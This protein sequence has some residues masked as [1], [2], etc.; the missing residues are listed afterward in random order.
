MTRDKLCKPTSRGDTI[1]V[2][3]ISTYLHYSLALASCLFVCSA[4]GSWEC[5]KPMVSLIALSKLGTKHVNKIAKLRRHSSSTLGCKPVRISRCY[6]TCSHTK[7][8]YMFIQLVHTRNTWTYDLPWGWSFPS[9]DPTPT[10]PLGTSSMVGYWD[11]LEGHQSPGCSSFTSC[12]SGWK[13]RAQLLQLHGNDSTLVDNVIA[14]KER[15]GLWEHH[16]DLV[17]VKMYWVLWLDLCTELRCNKSHVCM[18]YT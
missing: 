3:E 12:N 8:R 4:A 9:R 17:D 6:L 16:P 1:D 11:A 13:T 18:Q 10:A 15:E 14:R 5:Q 7:L 2:H